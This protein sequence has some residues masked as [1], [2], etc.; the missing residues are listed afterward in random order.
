[1]IMD[2]YSMFLSGYYRDYHW[3]L[4]DSNIVDIDSGIKGRL[5]G[6][7][8]VISQPGFG[9]VVYLNGQEAW[10]RAGEFESKT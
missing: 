8:K 9:Q 4:N 5:V 2:N 10:I 1:M 7:A 3:L 6:Q